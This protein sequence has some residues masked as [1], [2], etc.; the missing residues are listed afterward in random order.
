MSNLTNLLFHL[1]TVFISDIK[2]INEQTN[3]M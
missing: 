2:D 1:L 3:L